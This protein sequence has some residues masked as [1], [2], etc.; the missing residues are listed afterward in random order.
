[1]SYRLIALPLVALLATAADA[2]PLAA[3]GV[4]QPGRWSLSS[5]DADFA[6]RSICLGDARQLLQIRQPAAACSRYVI[7]NEPNVATVHYT[8]PGVGHGRTTVRVETPRVAQI[9]TQGMVGR[10]PFDLDIEARRLGDCQAL[11]MR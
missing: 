6:K 7:A 8:C 3:L 2:P 11:S 9:E 10:E 5:S 4:L 1:M